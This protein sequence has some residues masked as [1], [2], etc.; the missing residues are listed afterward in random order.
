MKT[1]LSLFIFL[2]FFSLLTVGDRA[3]AQT[4]SLPRTMARL[5]TR[6]DSLRSI[7]LHLK[8]EA[9]ALAADISTLQQDEE[10]T[11][12]EHRQLG[13]KLKKSQELTL[14]ME[15]LSSRIGKMTIRRDSLIRERIARLDS[16]IDSLLAPASEGERNRAGTKI[17]ELAREKKLLRGELSPA[18]LDH[19]EEEPIRA[20][21]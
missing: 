18:R 6:L 14:R 17:E 16:R 11:A 13:D 9:A 5:E 19:A 20:H 21:A 1:H 10:I 12:A 15:H 2:L 4:V 3:E 8:D 7:R